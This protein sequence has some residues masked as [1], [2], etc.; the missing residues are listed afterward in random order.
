MAVSL[1]RKPTGEPRWFIVF[2]I[3]AALPVALFYDFWTPSV[4]IR[5]SDFFT[6]DYLMWDWGWNHFF[7]EGRI[8]WWN[9]LLFGGWPFV[10]SF[11]FCPFYPPAWVSVPLPTS[12]AITTQVVLHLA[13]GMW[14]FYF[15][16]RGLRVSWPI[17]LLGA[18]L[19]GAGSHVTTLVF[20]GHLAKIQ[21]I[22]WVGWAM[23]AAVR[24]VWEP[25]LKWAV[26]LGAAWALQLLAS[27]AQIFY[28]TGWMVAGYVVIGAFYKSYKPHKPYKSYRT[29]G[30][31]A[32]A[33][34]LCI[35]FSAI[36]MFP[37]LAFAQRSNRAGGV[38]LQEALSDALPAEELWELVLPCFRGDSTG[39]L[40]TRDGATAT[41]YVGRWHG[42]EKGEGGERL[43][44][45]YIGIFPVLFALYG[46]ACARG[47]KRWFFFV[48]AV[49]GMLVSIGGATPLYALL[50]HYFP[51][52]NRYRSP[53][54][55]AIVTHFALFALSVLGMQAFM[56]WVARQPKAGRWVFNSGL[57]L[58]IVWCWSAREV[59]DAALRVRGVADYLF[60]RAASHDVLFLYGG[61]LGLGVWLLERNGPVRH[62]RWYA[63]VVG[64]TMFVG[65]ALVDGGSNA[66]R[67]LPRDQTQNF[68][69][70]LHQSPTDSLVLRAAQSQGDPSP[71]LVDPMRLNGN[72]SMMR[73]IRSAFGYHPAVFADYEKW[74]RAV[75]GVESPN[76][77]RQLAL[78][79]RTLPLD[80]PM[81]EPGW[82]VLA[83]IQGQRV[84]ARE[85]TIDFARVPLEIQGIGTQWT[86]LSEE[87][88]QKKIGGTFD[89]AQQTLCEGQYS[90]KSPQQPPR[91]QT[92]WLD[93]SALELSWA[94]HQGVD[95]KKMGDTEGTI[96]CLL[97]L[98]AAPGWKILSI[99]PEGKTTVL[100]PEWPKKANGN[101]FLVPLPANEN[102]RIALLYVAPGEKCGKTVTLLTFAALGGVMLIKRWKKKS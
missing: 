34:I 21:A 17:A 18:L 26:A 28:A 7:Q 39:K 72:R 91:V 63:W 36:Q 11:A 52:F 56:E 22:A 66:R 41:P 20:P 45:D 67:F 46:I 48:V 16:A 75:G 77:W 6:H 32:L 80:R 58:M 86:D 10:A 88:W 57:C 101:F 76:A 55:Y 23:G 84:L 78:N 99:S 44:S 19:Y 5:A 33:G 90:W 4:F 95:W 8:P 83:E 81:D 93:S 50:H 15:F 71:A 79:Y 2:L 62:K 97:A 69:A 1:W 65:M 82:A 94:P 61:L 25:R 73:G 9:P 59:Y 24:L 64:L 60:W 14:G 49:G 98:P 51:G 3:L 54:T 87:E 68:E 100:P 42:N 12:L 102:T 53:A 74:L 35:G 30:F 29:Y 37:S 43:V 13:I 38:E 70:Y 40:M 31:L 27:H 92:K 47:R 96:P 85:K 89:P